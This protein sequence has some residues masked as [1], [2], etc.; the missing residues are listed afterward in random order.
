MSADDELGYVYLPISTPSNDWYGGQRHGDG[1]FGESLVC[2]DARTGRRVWHF[3]MV[4]HGLWD[5]D[6][7]A[8][9]NLIDVR[10]NGTLVKAIA[11][12]YRWQGQ[13]EQG[14][15]AAAEDIALS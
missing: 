10:V 6:P 14:I 5:Y 1:L 8:A 4:H 3:Q 15:C 2:L 11:R 7:P 12:D 13:L 9:P